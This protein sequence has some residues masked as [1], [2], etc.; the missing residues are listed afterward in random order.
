MW[1]DIPPL[2]DN[3]K[4]YYIIDEY[5]NV[6]NK[7]TNV[8]IIP[9]ITDN[10]YLQVSLMTQTGRVFRKIHRLVML[11]F[12]YSPGCELLEVNH[13]DGNKFN[14]HISNLEWCTPKENKK[15]A[16]ENNL[17]DGL[18]G[19]ANPKAI[20][21]E[22]IARSIFNLIC[23]GLSDKEIA[24]IL[25][26]GNS[27]IVYNIRCGKTW[28]HLFTQSELDFMKSTIRTHN[29]SDQDR[30]RLCKFYQDNSLYYNGYGSVTKLIKDGLI[31]IGYDL[32]DKNIRS[33]KRLYYKYESPEIT[34]LYNY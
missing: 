17:S 22:N 5:A 29:I 7:N 6:K 25:C 19:S 14:N 1:L 11:V 16:I 4:P 32:S 9:H 8:L 24:N 23:Q 28:S 31:H 13:K 26:N 21:N 10:G 15:H 3:I 18:I 34:K 30:H 20:I 33:A 2:F 12:D 27:S